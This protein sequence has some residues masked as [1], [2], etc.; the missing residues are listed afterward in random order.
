MIFLLEAL[1]SIV[2][3]L[4]TI[5]NLLLSFIHYSTS[6]S[7]FLNICTTFISTLT[8]FIPVQFLPFAVIT[9]TLSVIFLI[10]G[11]RDSSG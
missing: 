2:L 8:T 1:N 4:G 10:V 5:W 3:F 7:R 9:I 6:L 11:R